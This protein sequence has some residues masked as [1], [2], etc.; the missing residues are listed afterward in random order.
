MTACRQFIFKEYKAKSLW[1]IEHDNQTTRV[2]KLACQRASAYCSASVL[3]KQNIVR[4]TKS[5]DVKLA[6]SICFN[7]CGGSICKD[8]SRPFYFFEFYGIIILGG[9]LLD[10]LEVDEKNHE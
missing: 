10:K 6:S 8:L 7:K 9:Y 2:D 3:Q 4:G 1:S 5:I